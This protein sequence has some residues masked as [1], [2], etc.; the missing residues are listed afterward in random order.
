MP[1]SKANSKARSNARRLQT[2][3]FKAQS[4][5]EKAIPKNTKKAY[6]P[7]QKEWRTF[8]REQKWEDGKTTAKEDERQAASSGPNWNE[9]VEIFF[10]QRLCRCYMQ[11]LAWP[12]GKGHC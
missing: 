1:S 5:I 11:A 12:G 9:Y 2:A 8:C 6:W 10:S 3:A 7:K 4:Q